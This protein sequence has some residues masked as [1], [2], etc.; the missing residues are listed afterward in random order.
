MTYHPR[1]AVMRKSYVRC[2]WVTLLSSVA[3]LADQ[4]AQKQESLGLIL[5]PGGAKLLREGQETPLDARAG[6][7]LYAGDGLRTTAG[8]AKCMFCPSK[9]L[10]TLTAAGEVRLDKAT[11]KVKTGKLSDEPLPRS[12]ILPTT[13]RVAVASQQHVGATLTRDGPEDYIPLATPRDKL[14]TKW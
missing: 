14:A 2:L 11:L 4:P 9:T 12:C 5:N 7:L 6:D 1:I 3:A 10:Q 8:P 13:L